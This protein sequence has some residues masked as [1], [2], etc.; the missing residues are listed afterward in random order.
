MDAAP[1]P[2]SV[3][4]RT[5]GTLIPES[6]D[7]YRAALPEVAVAVAWGAVPAAV[8]AAASAAWTGIDGREA[9]KAA[10]DA[11]EFGR[12][13]TASAL[14]LVSRAFGAAAA[15]A[16]YP[17]VAGRASGTVV[18]A[19]QAYAFLLERLWPLVK[20]F[21]RQLAYIL[22]GT[23]CLV[24]P[25]VVLAFR[26]ALTQQAVMLEGLS[27]PAALARSKEFMGR[28]AGKVVGNALVAW[29]LTLTG[30]LALF[31]VLGLGTAVFELFLPKAYHP[32][33]D[34]AQ[35]VAAGYLD[36]LAGAWLTAFFVNLYGDLMRAS[37]QAE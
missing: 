15:L 1:P 35:G 26:Y 33:A 14:G 28:Y 7:L 25:G 13:G 24:V 5:L 12:V 36:A 20:T 4:P 6:W 32:A 34:A 3:E 19:A 37:R 16:V 10:I 2:P 17:V 22:L 21:A 23:L 9:L 30:V 18:S 11:G 27:G 8:I 31:F 29:L